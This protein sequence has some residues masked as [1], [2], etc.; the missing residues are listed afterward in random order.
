MK[1]KRKGR[2]KGEKEQKGKGE[3]GSGG[4]YRYKVGLVNIH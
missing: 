3:E 4:D 1:G 2:R